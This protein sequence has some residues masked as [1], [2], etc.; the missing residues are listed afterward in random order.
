MKEYLVIYHQAEDGCWGAHCE[1]V[2]VFVVGATRAEAE[3]LVKEGIV[4]HIEY[5]L[6]QGEP[7]PEPC[8]E[9]G[10]VVID[11]DA[12]LTTPSA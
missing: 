10:R 2:D 5:G 8:A 4:L 9:V 12:L 6:E 7:I 11:T 3:R 1:D